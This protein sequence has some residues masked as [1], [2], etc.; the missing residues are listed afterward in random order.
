[1]DKTNYRP[2]TIL[3]T[4][5]KVFEKCL[6]PQLTSYFETIFPPTLTAYRKNHSCCSTLLK[7]TEDWKTEA[8]SNNI[9]G[10]TLID[11]SKAFDR[12]PH[13]LL[14]EKLSAY[15]VSLES[16]ELLTNYVKTENTMCQAWQHSLDHREANV[17][18][19]TRICTWHAF[20]QHF[21]KRSVLQH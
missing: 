11:L 5:S 20:I 4:I 8:D 14:L 13:N 12:L 7:L 3:P 15:G 16:L 19:P 21:Q 18:C 2:V 9:I 1:M 10:A 6:C 17:R